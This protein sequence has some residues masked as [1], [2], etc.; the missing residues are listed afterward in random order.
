MAFYLLEVK[1]QPERRELFLSGLF[2]GLAVETRLFFAALVPV[3]VMYVYFLTRKRGVQPVSMF[4]LGGI[5]AALPMIIFCC[6][7]FE[8]FWF[9]N[10]GYHLMR[11][12]KD[13]EASLK[14]KQT[15]FLTIFGLRDTLKFHGLQFPLLLYISFLGILVRLLR[16]SKISLAALILL[17][18]FAVNFLPTPSY[19]QYF[20]TLAPFAIIVLIETLK[21]DLRSTFLRKVLV[22]AFVCFGVEYFRVF[23]PDVYKYTRNG[24]GV[25]GVRSPEK[26]PDRKLAAMRSIAQMIDS[27][28]L[29]GEKILCFWP[30]YLID[31]HASAWPGLENHFSIKVADKVSPTERELFKILTKSEALDLIRNK[32]ARY[33][34]L[35][36]GQEKSRVKTLLKSYQQIGKRH[37]VSFWKLKA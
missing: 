11:S 23:L 2:L 8:S 35:S 29:A 9:N 27:Q 5:F 34:L 3:F 4:L 21:I 37:G 1:G 30:G 17:A 22:I 25:L 24:I 15:I 20:V 10:M 28:T 13:V 33:L 18:L 7:S 26:A 16:D 19:V 32:Q 14:N 6:I 36:P 12:S 31:S